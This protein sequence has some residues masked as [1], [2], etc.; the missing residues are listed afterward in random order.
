MSTIA[1]GS[2]RRILAVPEVSWG[3][4]VP[5]PDMFVVRNTGGAGIQ[6]DRNA[7]QSEEFR[8]DRAITEVRMGVQRA[9]MPIPFELSWQSFDEFLE[10]ALF[11]DW[12]AD[13]LKQGI[14]VHSFNIEEGYTDINVYLT[15]LGAMVD[16]FSLSLQP[17]GRIVTGTFGLMGRKL[18]DPES[19][20]ADADPVPSNTYPVF[21]SFTGYL[22]K[23]GAT[24][25]IATSLE[26]SLANNLAQQ[27]ALFQNEAFGITAGRANITGTATLYFTGKDEIEEFLNETESSLEFQLE[28]PAGNSYTIE[29]PRTKWSG[30]P[31]RTLNENQVTQQ[32]PF[33]AMYDEGEET[34]MVIT[35]TEAS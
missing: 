2:R 30:N 20:S 11:G 35:R 1:A 26:L 19:S 29:L 22:R 27:Y 12:T 34:S 15:M 17:E 9:T 14:E 33:Q 4:R 5:T 25:G 24:L 13:V 18:I 6:V 23:N 28:D 21:D 3:E 7:Q 16:T 10:A 8:S 31:Q 32:I